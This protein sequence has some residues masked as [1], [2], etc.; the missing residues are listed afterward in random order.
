MNKRASEDLLAELHGTLAQQFIARVKSGEATPSD[1]NA[2]RQFL[3]D[4]NISCVPEANEN[5]QHLAEALPTME[6]IDAL[7]ALGTNFQ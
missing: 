1:L 5:M 6:E 3:K 2:A 7:A 4:N